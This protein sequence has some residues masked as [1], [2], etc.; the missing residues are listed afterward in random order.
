MDEEV[1]ETE[2]AEV[3]LSDGPQMVT[4]QIL[5]IHQAHDAIVNEAI[6]SSTEP[7]EAVLKEFMTEEKK[8][9]L[10]N[11]LQTLK[12]ALD[13]IES[14]KQQLTEQSVTE[15]AEEVK[16]KMT[17]EQMFNRA[18]LLTIINADVRA[19]I[20][21]FINSDRYDA[22]KD[23]VEILARSNQIY[24]KMLDQLVE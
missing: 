6:V 3:V 2:E 11:R 20:S 22:F 13:V 21:N 14:K 4:H 16:P 24:K 15:V 18:E 12:A 9:E 5:G 23:A 8:Q 10:I 17:G 19:N 7:A 1:I